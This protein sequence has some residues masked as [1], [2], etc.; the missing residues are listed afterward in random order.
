MNTNRFL[1]IFWLEFQDCLNATGK[2]SSRSSNKFV[3]KKKQFLP[4]VFQDEVVVVHRVHVHRGVHWALCNKNVAFA[5]ANF[6]FSIFQCSLSRSLSANSS[7]LARSM[8]FF[9]LLTSFY[10]HYVSVFSTINKSK[11][12]YC[13]SPNDAFSRAYTRQA[14]EMR[15]ESRGAR[16]LLRDWKIQ[17]RFLRQIHKIVKSTS[18]SA[19]NS[20]RLFL[21]PNISKQLMFKTVSRLSFRVSKISVETQKF[22]SWGTAKWI[23]FV[24]PEFLLVPLDLCRHNETFCAWIYRTLLQSASQSFIKTTERCRHTSLYRHCNV[25]LWPT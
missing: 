1:Y 12:N 18:H 15:K 20:A 14:N 19:H 3:K 4:V 7:N 9:K 11:K 24:H 21:V 13:W 23:S 8:R 17:A 25:Q 22:K 16:L 5:T 6:T 10:N 2:P